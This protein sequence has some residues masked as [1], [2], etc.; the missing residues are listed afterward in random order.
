VS[1]ASVAGTNAPSGDVTS[2]RVFSLRA[3]SAIGERGRFCA[4]DSG[5]RFFP[6]V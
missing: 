6:G 3:S 4:G 2:T 1:L 5:G